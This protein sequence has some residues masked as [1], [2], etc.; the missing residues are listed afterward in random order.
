MKSSQRAF[1][2]LL[3]IGTALFLILNQVGLISA[4]I[5]VG[6]ILMGVVCIAIFVSGVVEK[7]FG[8][9]FISLGLAW[10]VFG[11]ILG[12]PVASW[13]IVLAI[14]ILLTVG[15]H[16]LF[17]MSSTH[18]KKDW[19]AYEN[20]GEIGEHQK[21]ENIEDNGYISSSNSF[22]ATAKYINYQDFRGASLKNSFG[23]M[24]VYFDNAQIQ[25]DTI[26]INVS[27]SFGE[28]RL[29]IPRTWNVQPKVTVFAGDFREN[30][31]PLQKEGPA[32][33]IIGNVSFGD[34]NITYV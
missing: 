3:L 16:V 8:G 32:V 13:P 1:W 19:S 5:G 25:A 30:N 7:S 24:K 14:V 26:T 31:A 15:F 27:N 28:M 21:V 18:H 20:D 4:D 2:G 17:P 23:E 9:I 10:L 11:P 22:G 34:I 6:T 33:N 29:F 12:I